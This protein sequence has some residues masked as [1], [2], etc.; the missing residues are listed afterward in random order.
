MSAASKPCARCA[1]YLGDWRSHGPTF[2]HET[3]EI[4]ESEEFPVGTHGG[5]VGMSGRA[6]CRACGFA[7]TFGC[8]YG[9]GYWFSPAGA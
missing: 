8:S 4:L 6:R 2:P 9:P 3:W 1:G 5:S 7:A